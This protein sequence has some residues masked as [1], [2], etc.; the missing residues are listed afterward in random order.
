MLRLKDLF[1]IGI[2]TIKPR[3]HRLFLVLPRLI[4]NSRSEAALNSATDGFWCQREVVSAKP[5]VS[6]LW[7]RQEVGVEPAGLLP[8]APISWSDRLWPSAGF[9][10]RLCWDDRVV[11]KEVRKWW[12]TSFAEEEIPG[13]K[14]AIWLVD[15]RRKEVTISRVTGAQR[16]GEGSHWLKIYDCDSFG[17]TWAHSE[18]LIQKHPE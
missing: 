17:A 4:W 15:W 11:K 1:K 12:R 7:Q 10:H 6:A 9:D 16:S 14:S 18:E 3:G 2:T 5:K 13:R 8:V